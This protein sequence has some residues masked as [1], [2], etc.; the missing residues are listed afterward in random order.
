[1][2]YCCD[3]WMRPHC[4][5]QKI[6]RPGGPHE[7]CRNTRA[8]SGSVHVRFRGCS[9]FPNQRGFGHSSTRVGFRSASRDPRKTPEIDSQVDPRRSF[10]MN[11]V[12]ALLFVCLA[13]LVA[14]GVILAVPELSPAWS[15]GGLALLS[16]ALLA[17]RRGRERQF[18]T[19]SRPIRKRVIFEKVIRGAAAA[20]PEELRGIRR[21]ARNASANRGCARFAIGRRKAR[22]APSI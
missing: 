18:L 20:H 21:T 11:P 2:R 16:C 12:G 1:M 15:L 3:W 7:V 17:S 14:G 19:Q 6:S 8:L 22:L 5:R 13:G 4:S 10:P 9:M